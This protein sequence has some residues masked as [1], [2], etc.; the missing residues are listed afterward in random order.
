MVGRYVGVFST[1]DFDLGCTKLVQHKIDIGDT[2]PI[3]QALRWVPV[4]LQEEF[5]KHLQDV[6]ERGIVSPSISPWAAPVV[7][8]RKKDGS[9]R[10]CADYRR[11]N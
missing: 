5:D 4:H 3:K 2:R 7:L 9:I 10:L 8:V 6:L 1:D 11:L